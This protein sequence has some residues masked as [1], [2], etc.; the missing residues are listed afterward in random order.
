MRAV[1][2]NNN[3]LEIVSQEIPQPGPDD[4]VIEVRAAGLNA[5]E[6]RAGI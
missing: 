4:V 6:V 3:E 1:K 5:A 2:I